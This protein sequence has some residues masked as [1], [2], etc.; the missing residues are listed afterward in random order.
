MLKIFEFYLTFPMNSLVCCLDMCYTLGLV[1]VED[2][3]RAEIHTRLKKTFRRHSS[4]VANSQV[5]L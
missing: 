4:D 2:V 3:T 1:V 5:L